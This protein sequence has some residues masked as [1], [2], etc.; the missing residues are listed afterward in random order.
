MERFKNISS[1][2]KAV[3]FTLVLT[4][5]NTLN[6]FAGNVIDSD[7]SNTAG[8]NLGNSHLDIYI[9]IIALLILC[10]VIPYWEDKQ[11]AKKNS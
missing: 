3:L 2:Y 10:L 11:K 8:S 1:S 7:M 6:T 9:F 5:F 4:F